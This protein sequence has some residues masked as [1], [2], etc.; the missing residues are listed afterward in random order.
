MEMFAFSWIVKVTFIT[1]RSERT[2]NLFSPE[3]IA[4]KDFQIA[5]NYCKK[6]SS[7]FYLQTKEFLFFFKQDLHA[8][9]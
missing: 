6:K 5:T 1:D 7:F 8:L 3:K 9:Q 4:F 2:K